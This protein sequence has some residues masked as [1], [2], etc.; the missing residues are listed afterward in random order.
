MAFF[1]LFSFFCKSAEIL[2]YKIHGCV[3]NIP[4]QQ[5]V[6]ACHI[7]L[8]SHITSLGISE[9]VQPMML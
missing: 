7:R 4:F 2:G 3:M 9:S 6:T 5:K 8:W 1:F